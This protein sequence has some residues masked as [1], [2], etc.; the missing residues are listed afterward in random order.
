MMVEC[1]RCH[2]ENRDDSRF[3]SDC[4]APLGP[5]ACA[6][7]EGASVTRTLETPLHVLKVG[8]LVAGKYRIVEEVGLTCPLSIIPASA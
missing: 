1:P 8:T 3:C 2:A 4:A 5:G 7:P 6:G